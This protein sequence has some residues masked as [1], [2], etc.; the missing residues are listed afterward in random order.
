MKHLQAPR[1][2]TRVGVALLVGAVTAVWTGV[3]RAAEL[4]TTVL[5]QVESGGQSVFDESGSH[6]YVKDIVVF[7]VLVAIA[8]IAICYSSRRT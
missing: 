8:I 3:A 4:T 7:V 1:C 5:A 2:H 6:S